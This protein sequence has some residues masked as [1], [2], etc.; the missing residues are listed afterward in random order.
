MGMVGG[1]PG[2]MIGD[3]HRVT[4]MAKG[5]VDFVCGCFSTDT[6]KNQLKGEELGLA[7]S[8]VYATIAELLEGEL[9]LPENERMDFL[10]I[11]TPNHL[12]VDAAIKA[13]KSGFH[14][15]CDKPLGISV[16]E[17]EELKSVVEQSGL[18]FGMTYTYRGY[19]A[20]Q[21]IGKIVREG[22]IGNIRKVLIDY[23]QGWLSSL[24]EQ[25]GNRQATWR[26]NPEF[27]GMGGT[28]AD[29][30]THAFNMA[31]FVAGSNV[32]E[33]TAQVSTLVEGR[34][35]DD[36]A[37]VLVK[38]ENG[39]K[40]VVTVGQALTGEE[41]SLRVQVHGSKGSLLWNHSKPDEVVLKADG[42]VRNIF[43]SI[44]QFDTNKVNEGLTQKHAGNFLKGFIH[45]YDAFVES[46]INDTDGGYPSIIDGLRGMLFI[47]KSL[48]S[49]KT[50]KW[51][52]LTT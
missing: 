10:A 32:T 19:S 27:S 15:M 50:G 5:K 13:L 45:I 38:F 52:K 34:N 20:I 1:G 14:V 16:S 26:T 44:S 35:I 23:S 22:E 40:G 9:S 30:G 39:A 2:S 12:H 46:I 17:A 33:L 36:D 37:N 7:K 29:I 3:V 49:S 48:E 51:V 25:E 4:A 24:A 47:E 8:R 41:N 11:T 42:D 18:K 43:V 28:I 21:K 6:K 31:E